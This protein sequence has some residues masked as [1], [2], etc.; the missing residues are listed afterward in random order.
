M[1]RLS[2]FAI[3]LFLVTVLAGCATGPSGGVSTTANAKI[4]ACR[5]GDTTVSGPEQC[6]QD[7][8]ACY[9]TRSGDWCTGERGNT[10]PAGSV[11]IP[12]GSACPSGMRCFEAGESLSCAISYQ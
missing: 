11:Q 3:L 4:E 7:D 12:Y 5:S 6:L 1:Q 10:C 9:Q 2:L 8:A